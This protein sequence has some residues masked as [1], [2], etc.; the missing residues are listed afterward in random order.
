MQEKIEAVN[1]QASFFEE[2][3]H[4]DAPAIKQKKE[5]LNERYQR[6]QVH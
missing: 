6:L 2:A 3:D 4:F 1:A 5:I